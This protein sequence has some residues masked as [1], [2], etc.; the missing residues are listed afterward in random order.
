VAARLL[1]IEN[2]F[3]AQRAIRKDPDHKIVRM[4]DQAAR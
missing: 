1:W 3:Y 4:L 2:V